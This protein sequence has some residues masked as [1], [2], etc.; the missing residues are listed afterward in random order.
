[1]DTGCNGSLAKKWHTVTEA[2]ISGQKLWSKPYDCTKQ[3]HTCYLCAASFRQ[4]VKNDSLFERHDNP[5]MHHHC[6]GNLG[7]TTKCESQAEVGRG[8][9]VQVVEKVDKLSKSEVHCKVQCH[10]WKSVA[11]TEFWG[12]SPLWK[13]IQHE[14]L[15]PISSFWMGM[16]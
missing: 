1:M 10:Q 4:K 12:T 11:L 15:T 2:K 13:N 14:L 6:A 7:M 8:K 9:E 5:T 16:N 3:A